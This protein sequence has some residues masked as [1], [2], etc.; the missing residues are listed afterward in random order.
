MKKEI[1]KNIP[2]YEWLYQA[3]NLWNIK[4]LPKKW[5]WWHSWKILKKN[6]NNL[7]YV[8]YTLVINKQKKSY[9]WH[10][11]IA[12]VF[13]NNCNNKS[14]VNHKNWIKNDNRVENLEWCTR[15]ENIIHAFKTWLNKISNKNNFISN[16]PYLW[17]YWSNCP[18]SKKINQFDINWIFIRTWG[19][20]TDIKNKL[21][22]N[23]WHISACCRLKR[24]TAWWFIWKYFNLQNK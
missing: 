4:S 20:W 8:R 15:K 6:N 23:Q 14:D 17:K 13:I 19:S 22:I 12:T 24:K 21:K 3:S 7:W 1:W 16:H 18:N 2:W 11:L 9:L 5:T 10:R